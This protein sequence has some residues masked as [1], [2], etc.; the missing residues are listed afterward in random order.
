[1]KKS[2]IRCLTVNSLIEELQKLQ[3]CGKGEYI[4]LPLVFNDSGRAY[5]ESWINNVDDEEKCVTIGGD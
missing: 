2:D 5:D 4:I 3:S 1:M